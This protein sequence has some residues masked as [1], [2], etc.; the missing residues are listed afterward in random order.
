[1]L[2]SSMCGSTVNR[3]IKH[4]ATEIKKKQQHTFCC[5]LVFLAILI[6]VRDLENELKKNS[7]L[8]AMCW[9]LKKTD[10]KQFYNSKKVLYC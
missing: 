4:I 3:T 5:I 2:A 9:G 10:V 6:Q 8:P 7:A 1:M